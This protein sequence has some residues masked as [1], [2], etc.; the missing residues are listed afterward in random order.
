MATLSLDLTK[1]ASETEIAAAQKLQVAALTRDVDET[2]R[3]LKTPTI[4]SLLKRGVLRIDR[5]TVL[6]FEGE[7][8]ELSE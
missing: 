7:Q 3:L 2:N 6:D 4:K 5:R 8:H 1:K